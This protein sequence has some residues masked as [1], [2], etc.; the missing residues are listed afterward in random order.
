MTKAAAQPFNHLEL[1]EFVETATVTTIDKGGS[2]REGAATGEHDLEVK[3]T[4]LDEVIQMLEEM[5]RFSDVS[6]FLKTRAAEKGK[7]M[8]EGV[9]IDGGAGGTGNGVEARGEVG[10]GK[11]H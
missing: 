5:S 11:G 2:G 9:R 10:D 7:G 4:A 6:A 3:D 8:G 1:P